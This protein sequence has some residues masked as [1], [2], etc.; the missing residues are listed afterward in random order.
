MGFR[1]FIERQA[2]ELEQAWATLGRFFLS[3]R[4]G[5]VRQLPASA[6]ELSPVQLYALTLLAEGPIRIGELSGQLGLAESTTT[7]MVDRL[8]D[9][10]LARRVLGRPERRSVQ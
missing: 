9:L 2:G 8:E 6:A 1:A 7:R 10:G 5:G 4:R 3:R